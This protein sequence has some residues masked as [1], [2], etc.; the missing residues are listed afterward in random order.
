MWQPGKWKQ[1]YCRVCGELKTPENTTNSGEHR[2]CKKVHQREWA[3]KHVKHSKRFLEKRNLKAEGLKR[4]TICGEMKQ[5]TDDNFFWDKRGWYRGECK[6]C[7]NDKRIEKTRANGVKPHRR[8][9]EEQRQKRREE[10]NRKQRERYWADERYRVS[11]IEYQ[12]EHHRR[13]PWLGIARKHKRKA[14]M[15]SRDDGS[16]TQK[17]LRELMRRTKACPYCGQSLEEQ[18]IEIDHII[19]LSKG[20]MHTRKNIVACCWECN[21][22]K[23]N[24]DFYEWYLEIEEH[25]RESVARLFTQRFGV[26]PEQAS[27]G[28][29]SVKSPGSG[30]RRSSRVPADV[31][32]PLIF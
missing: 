5:E 15:L 23:R 25:I 3:R 7:F 1:Q 27:L 24:K 6:Q 16:V 26:S 8:L 31:E 28:L 29:W 20:G 10:Q 4:C 9:S 21:Q 12:R 19:P 11:C 18:R 30:K 14:M 13:K 32:F 22:K 2:P 17:V